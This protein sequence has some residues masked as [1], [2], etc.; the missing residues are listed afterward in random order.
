VDTLQEATLLAQVT[1]LLPSVML[2]GF[3][4][5]IDNMPIPLQVISHIFPAR[6]FVVII[7]GIM[8]KG[9]GLEVMLP[10]AGA[11]LLLMVILMTIAAAKFKTRVA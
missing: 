10:Q 4:F 5:A 9:A 8:L 7:R 2:S 6:F 11:L 3:I 1:T